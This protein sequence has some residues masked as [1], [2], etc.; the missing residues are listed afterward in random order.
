MAKKGA[1]DT[2]Y[3]PNASPQ[4]PEVNQFDWKELEEFIIDELT[5]KTVSVFSGLILSEND[6]VATYIDSIT[7]QE[8]EFKIPLKFWKIVYYIFE[9]TLKRIA[10]VFKQDEIV[11]GFPFIKASK[12]VLEVVDPFDFLAEDLKTY[13]VNPTIIEEATKLKFTPAANYFDLNPDFNEVS[14]DFKTKIAVFNKADLKN[15]L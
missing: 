8:E 6:P 4:V 13:I 12:P 7:K 3:Y 15:Y 11:L 10:F 9:N 14:G 5:I 2:F 1:D